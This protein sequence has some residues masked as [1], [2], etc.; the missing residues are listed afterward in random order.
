MQ[1]ILV[2]ICFLWP[3]FN[4]CI[5]L[6]AIIS[7][8]YG[9]DY[10]RLMAYSNLVLLV[11]GIAFSKTFIVMTS[12]TAKLWFLYY[13]GYFAMAI[14]AS[15]LSGS[16]L[17]SMATMI[18]IIYFTASYFFITNERHFKH[19]ILV[20]TSA[21]VVSSFLTLIFHLNNFS[22]ETGGVHH[23]E[24]DRAEGVYSDANNAALASLMAFMFC[25]TFFKPNKIYFKIIKWLILLFVFYS[26]FLTFSTTGL[27]TFVICFF[28]V[29][30][31]KFTGL[32]LILLLIVIVLFYGGIFVLKSEV[33]SLNLS[34]A[35]TDKVMN[36]VN[37][38][39]FQLDDVDNSGRGEL[40]EHIIPYIIENPIIGNGVDFSILMRGH[41]TFLGVWADSGIFLFLFFIFILVYF[42]YKLINLKTEL[43][44]LGISVLIILCIFMMSLQ[45]V[46]NQPYLIVLF[47]FLS[48]MID[49]EVKNEFQLISENNET[50]N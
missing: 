28:V 3:V 18:P 44:F 50:P 6:Q 45:S 36:I 2:Y 17:L 23:Y 46:L 39:T 38:L 27:F 15:G 40:L 14:L 11:I 26:L 32:R 13:L 47:T 33:N 42:F 29:N 22:L 7:R 35:Q 19:F 4:S 25:Y 30:F 21:F 49:L 12:K 20:A 16:G 41:N 10:G 8:F 34:D 24:L 5:Y 9:D 31:K 1:R 43:K 37:L 48:Y